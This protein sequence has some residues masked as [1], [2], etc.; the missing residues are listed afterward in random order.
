MSCEQLLQTPLHALDKRAERFNLR[1][2]EQISKLSVGEEHDEEHDGKAQDIFST[3]TQCGGQLS[4]GLVKTDVLEN[5]KDTMTTHIFL[6]ILMIWLQVLARMVL[7]L[8]L[9]P[10]EEQVHCIHVV[11]LCLPEG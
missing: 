7:K 10:G 4:H 11:V 9:D 3:S 8:Y 6:L 1:P 5:L 2:K